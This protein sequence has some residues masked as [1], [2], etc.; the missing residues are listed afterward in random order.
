[1]IQL[2]ID[3][4]EA[5]ILRDILASDLSELGYEIANTDAKD[6]RDL[7]KTKQGLLRRVLGQLTD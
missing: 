7:L 1:M 2:D 5:G 6:F 4:N 3:S